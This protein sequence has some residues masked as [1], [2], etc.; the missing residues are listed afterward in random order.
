MCPGE[1]TLR[2]FW[3]SQEGSP[4]LQGHEIR[5][6]S[7]KTRCVPLAFHGDGTPTTGCGKSWAKM[8]DVFSWHSV[9]VRGSS[10]KHHLYAWLMFTQLQV[11]RETHDKLFRVL[12]WSFS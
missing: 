7:Y 2:E 4:L 10:Q 1:G 6:R 8:T 12:A 11:G 9:P 3:A 5:Q